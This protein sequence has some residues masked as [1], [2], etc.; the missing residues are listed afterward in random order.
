M[1]SIVFYIYPIHLI[2]IHEFT[3]S[4]LVKVCYTTVS[5]IFYHVISTPNYSPQ[6]NLHAQWALKSTA[7]P[8]GGCS[9][10]QS[11]QKTDVPS[12]PQSR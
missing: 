2:L 5:A 6:I 11:L 3:R 1:K 10:S 12:A 8:C 4:D 9:P 7:S